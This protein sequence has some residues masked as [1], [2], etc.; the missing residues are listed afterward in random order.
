MSSNVIEVERGE[1]FG[2][3]ENWARFLSVLDERRIAEAERSLREMLGAESL[4]GRSFLDIGSGSGLFSLAARR[5][6]ARVR[7]FDYDPR[8]VACTRELRRRY[9]GEDGGWVVEE[10]SA[11]DE[12]YVRSLG[13]FDVVYSWGVL[14]HTGE[15]W[16]ALENARLPVREGGKLFVAIYNDAGWRSRVWWQIKRAYNLCPRPLRLPFTL[17]ILLPGQ[18]KAAA[19]AAARLRLGEFVRSWTRHDVNRGMSRWHDAIDWLGGFPYEVATPAEI[20]SFYAARGFRLLRTVPDPHY[21]LG[22]NEFV[23][24]RESADVET[25]AVESVSREGDR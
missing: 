13:L 8:S 19:V 12:S 5:L 16:R 18:A 23:F 7:S 17:A 6:G 15:M 24:V 3:G 25:A 22:C 1:R 4:E 21:D 2:F 11:L 9:F 10:G 20:E 14:H